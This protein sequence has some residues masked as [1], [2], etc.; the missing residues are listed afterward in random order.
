MATTLKTLLALVLVVAVWWSMAALAL[1]F[2]T[3]QA[4]IRDLNTTPPAKEG[5]LIMFDHGPSLCCADFNTALASSLWITALS[6][7]PMALIATVANRRRNLLPPSETRQTLSRAAMIFQGAS[8]ATNLL[9]AY[10]FVS[11]GFDGIFE[12]GFWILV[13]QALVG[14]SAVP[15]WYRLSYSVS[16]AQSVAF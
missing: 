11:Y 8:V 3:I 10:A 13:G 2:D 16:P 12:L 14:L 7:I 5:L 15:L 1:Y 4:G 9:I 6:A